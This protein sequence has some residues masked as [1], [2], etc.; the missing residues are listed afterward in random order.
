MKKINVKDLVVKC[1][2]SNAANDF[3]K[4]WHYS[5]KV[6]ANSQLHF[7][8][9]HEK[10]LKGVLSFGPSL[11]KSKLVGIVEGT[12]WNEFIELNR[13]AF[14]D[15]LP[16]N[17]ESRCLSI[18]IREIKKKCPHI[19]WIVT[20]AD[21]MQC[22][23]GGIYRACGFLL[24]G[25][26]KGSMWKLPE[27]LEKI[28]EGKVAHRMKVQDKGS[29]LSKYILSQ[30]KGK[31]LTM[32]GCRD[33]FGGSLLEGYM[34]RYIYILDKGCKEKINVKIYPY[35]KIKD[36]KAQMYKGACIV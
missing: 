13:V 5:K 34:F 9:F 33:K 12:G 36:M 14:Y 3:V 24:C 20:F 32:E 25:F 6:V 8:V 35:S 27:Y 26:S 19:K 18:A 29:K 10:R 7:G 16:K 22:G 4:K 30:T 21:G 1:I 23:D 11:D 28:N 2:K 17:S 15:D 31:N